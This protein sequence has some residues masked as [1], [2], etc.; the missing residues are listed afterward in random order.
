MTGTGRQ[1]D[2]TAEGWQ[3]AAMIQMQL[4]KTEPADAQS[5]LELTRPNE[6][7]LRNQG[8]EK[9]FESSGRAPLRHFK[10]P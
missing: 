6:G 4:K 2:W 5:V 8:L 9:Q 1:W 7:T 10:R 3:S